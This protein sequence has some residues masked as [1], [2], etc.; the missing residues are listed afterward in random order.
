MDRPPKVRRRIVG[1]TSLDRAALAARFTTAPARTVLTGQSSTDRY[2]VMG[3]EE[4]VRALI[5]DE[6]RQS[7]DA[8]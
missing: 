7:M 4:Q 2:A 1:S 6:R 3:R 8:P 5:L